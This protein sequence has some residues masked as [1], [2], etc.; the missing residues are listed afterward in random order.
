MYIIA[1]CCDIKQLST[2]LGDLNLKN[3]SFEQ[4]SYLR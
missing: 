4:N 3:K 1:L 2:I